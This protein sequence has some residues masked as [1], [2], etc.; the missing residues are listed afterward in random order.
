MSP[1][2]GPQLES[3][4]HHD[5]SRSIPS[6][7]A[8]TCSSTYLIAT[9][10]LP[11][12]PTCYIGSI[13]GTISWIDNSAS[14][15]IVSLIELIPRLTLP[16]AHLS[17]IPGEI[18]IHSSMPLLPTT[19]VDDWVTSAGSTRVI[20][21]TLETLSPSNTGLSSSR[22]SLFHHLITLPLT[23]VS[24][25]WKTPYG[26]TGKL[27]PLVWLVTIILWL[28]PFPIQGITL[29]LLDPIVTSSCIVGRTQRPKLE[30][31]Q[32]LLRLEIK[33]MDELASLDDLIGRDI[34]CKSCQL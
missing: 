21:H 5:P 29:E 28:L 3:T 30:H 9:L 24:A 23:S 15:H 4:H 11:I 1:N 27:R 14:T 8:L 22:W 7:P 17:L 25:S 10:W 16:N 31:Y 33:P 2:Q 32:K 18:A 12:C 13:L 19:K 26:S 6:I 20:F 34:R